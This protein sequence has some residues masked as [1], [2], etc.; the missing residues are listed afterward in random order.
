[1]LTTIGTTLSIQKPEFYLNIII[2]AAA[3]VII[4]LVGAYKNKS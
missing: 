2:L 1:M 4:G 3:A